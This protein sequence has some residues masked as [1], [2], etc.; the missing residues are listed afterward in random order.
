MSVATQN[1]PTAGMAKELELVTFYVGDL[2]IGAEIEH[3]EEIN[4]HLD[5]TPVP[6]ASEFVRGV[7]NLRGDVVTVLDLRKILGLDG[8]EITAQTRNVVVAYR[9]E[10]VGLLVDRIAEVVRTRAG[11]IDPPP[12]NVHG[13]AG[14]FFKGVCKLEND[15]L[16]VIDVE[17]VLH[18]A[19][20]IEKGRNRD[21]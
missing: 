6:Q 10:R 1:H 14:R 12:A 3:V 7:I 11:D 18:A 20:V 21:S 15:L 13:A 8:A 5:L 17:G 2:L 9:D 16:V 4:R 19:T